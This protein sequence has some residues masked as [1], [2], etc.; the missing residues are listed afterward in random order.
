ME[1]IMKHDTKYRK[2]TKKRVQSLKASYFS[3]IQSISYETF[4]HVFVMKLNGTNEETET[5]RKILYQKREIQSV[6]K[7]TTKSY[8][9]YYSTPKMA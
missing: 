5:E 3:E 7:V 8:Q 1:K 6:I 4:C 9:G 2:Y